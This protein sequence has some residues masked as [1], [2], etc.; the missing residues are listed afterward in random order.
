MSYLIASTKFSSLYAVLYALFFFSFFLSCVGFR[1][2]IIMPRD[3]N[4][5]LL[6]FEWVDDYYSLCANCTGRVLTT[7]D[8]G[9]SAIMARLL[10]MVFLILIASSFALGKFKIKLG[11]Y[12]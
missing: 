7:S 5:K 11:K 10:G 6:R 3:F 1:A 12:L 8:F 4:A 9:A 2:S